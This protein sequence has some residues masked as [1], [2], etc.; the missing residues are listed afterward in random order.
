MI[1][2]VT[3]KKISNSQ[4]SATNLQKV[5]FIIRFFFSQYLG[6]V[7]FE[8]KYMSLFLF[9]WFFHLFF[10]SWIFT[11]Y[12]IWWTLW[13]WIDTE[14]KKE[15]ITLDLLQVATSS[16]RYLIWERDKIILLWNLKKSH[17]QVKGCD[18][19]SILSAGIYNNKPAATVRAKVIH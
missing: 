6:R 13:R 14:N 3:S 8:T 9:F 17:E 18:E 7:I 1:C 15:R 2:S 19:I 10:H 16:I 12:V 5:L 11:V 4:P